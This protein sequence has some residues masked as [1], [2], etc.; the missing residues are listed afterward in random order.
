[1]RKLNEDFRAAPVK[2][3]LDKLVASASDDFGTQLSSLAQVDDATL[4]L[5]ERFIDDMSRCLKSLEGH[6][7]AE[8]SAGKGCVDD[9]KKLIEEV[10]LE[11]TGQLDRLGGQ[12]S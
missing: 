7:Q 12:A 10:L 9:T 5:I 3:C 2:E 8:L 4:K 1:M 11:L 6:L